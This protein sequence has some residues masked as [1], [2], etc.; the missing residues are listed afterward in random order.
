MHP[1]F[2]SN[3]TTHIFKNFGVSQIT[4]IDFIFAFVSA[5]NGFHTVVS[6]MHAYQPTYSIHSTA[7][8]VSI[9]I[10]SRNKI[11]YLVINSLYHQYIVDDVIIQ[12]YCFFFCFS[13]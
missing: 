8:S 6:T 4:V 3:L 11:F 12:N 2:A 13:K 5:P 9:L 7:Y 10:F 1:D